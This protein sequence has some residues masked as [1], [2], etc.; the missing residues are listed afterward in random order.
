V[1]VD[2]ITS[3]GKTTIADELAELVAAG[4]R[5]TIR[6]SMDGFHHRA[7]HRHRQGRLSADGYYED[8]YDL[9]A[10][11]RDLLAPLGPGGDLRYRRRTIDLA[12]DTPVSDDWRTAQPGS[13][14]IVDG[15]FLQ[16]PE[17]RAGWDEVVFVAVNFDVALARGVA[18]EA[19]D[20]GGVDAAREAFEKRYHAAGHRYLDE[21]DP[22]A[23]ASIVIDNND[24]D[25]PLI[26]R[27]G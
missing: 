24:L 5:D 22:L 26:S 16:R 3:S 6:V 21:I 9:D 18:R 17:L 8:A 15:S 1:G 4:G 25:A 20:L 10:A 2:G 13:I 12:R 23:R 27:L 11:A 7:E 14:V 19:A